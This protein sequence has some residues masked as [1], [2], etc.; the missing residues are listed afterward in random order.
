MNKKATVLLPV[1]NSENYIKECID[2]IL[3]QTYTDFDLLIIDDDSSD[4]SANLI[5][6]YHDERIIYVKNDKNLGLTNNLNK[7]IDL[8]D[9]QYI[10]RMDSDDICYPK[11]F[12]KQ[13]TYMDN[14]PEIALS[15]TSAVAFNENG[16]RKRNIVS[17]A[18]KGIRTELLFD[19]TIKHP[20]VIF[21]NEI[22][23]KENYRYS[24]KY[25]ATEDYAL[26]QEIASK[27]DIGNIQDIL[28]KYRQNESGITSQANKNREERDNA[29]KLV[30]REMLN[31]LNV[32]YDEDLLNIYRQFLTGNLEFTDENSEKLSILLSNVKNNLTIEMFDLE[33]F[34]RQASLHFRINFQFQNKNYGFMLKVYKKYFSTIFEL[35]KQDVIKLIVRHAESKLR[36]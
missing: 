3:S 7:G 4:N 35:N 19:C 31:R 8:I 34:S 22:I 11:R 18:P 20:S 26:W 14:N 27:Y 23:K 15:G 24:T 1:Y 17:T 32:K 6:E 28:L 30:Y 16:Y 33:N 29:H 21:R 10:I 12:Q 5:K 36:R 9:S 13:I 25:K 2:S